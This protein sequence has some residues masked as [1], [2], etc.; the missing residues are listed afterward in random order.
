M[1][2]PVELRL[3]DRGRRLDIDWDDQPTS[4]LSARALRD[5]CRCAAC[6]RAKIDGRPLAR[7]DMIAVAGIDPVGEY[8]VNLRFSD[9]HAR[10]IF[11]WAYLREIAA[12]AIT[13][14]TGAEPP[15]TVPAVPH[16][17]DQA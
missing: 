11:P 15:G 2:P 13:C 14:S 5:A 4:H 6:T 1:T 17:K 9:G 12:D 8:A 7:D 16:R 10:G 3:S